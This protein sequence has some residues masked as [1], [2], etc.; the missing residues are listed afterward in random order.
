M[1]IS[2]FTHINPQS[3]P[4]SHLPLATFFA[5]E[6]E[7]L[8]NA[9]EG[10]RPKISFIQDRVKRQMSFT[11]RKAGIMKKA[12]DLSILT[13]TEVLLIIATDSGSVFSYATSQLKR[14]FEDETGA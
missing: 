6:L 13:G 5:A 12:H 1:P 8:N 7:Q 10:K 4:P 9:P 3:T 14:F 11:K 2:H